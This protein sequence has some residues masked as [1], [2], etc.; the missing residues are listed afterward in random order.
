MSCKLCKM[1]KM[2]KLDYNKIKKMFLVDEL[3]GYGKVCKRFEI[4]CDC[5]DT[6]RE[7][8]EDFDNE[9]KEFKEMK[10]I[11]DGDEYNEGD[12]DE[13]P[14]YLSDDDSEDEILEQDISSNELSDDENS[15]P[16]INYKNCENFSKHKVRHY[17]NEYYLCPKCY[18]TN[19]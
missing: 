2:G 16:C 19:F 6:I 3:F 1:C 14:D 18:K 8:Q 7:I 11:P 13:M 15:P 10:D 17:L 9:M 12:N 4:C 5:E